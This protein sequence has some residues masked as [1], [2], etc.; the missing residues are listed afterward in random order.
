MTWAVSCF[1]RS[2]ARAGGVYGVP[3]RGCQ[4]EVEAQ[5]WTMGVSQ[6]E[7]EHVTESVAGK[8]SGV[9][10]ARKLDGGLWGVRSE[11]M[12]QQQAACSPPWLGITHAN[13]G[14]DGTL[15]RWSGRG[16]GALMAML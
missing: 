8:D 9:C 5:V 6:T 7:E 4:G 14:G 16:K 2:L 12:Q 11:G 1:Y 13:V 3:W 15:E 10:K